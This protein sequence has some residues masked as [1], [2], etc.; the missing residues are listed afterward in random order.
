MAHSHIPYGQ[1][2]IDEADIEA[3]VDVLRSDWITQGELVGKFEEAL[4]EY[5][6]ANFAVAV[7]SATAALH[8][9]CM[10]AG[11]KT[12]QAV[13]TSPVIFDSP[14]PG[15]LHSLGV[16]AKTPGSGQRS[17]VGPVFHSL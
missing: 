17:G 14:V 12:G 3:V 13:L 8:L 9:A 11:V 15:G 5:C 6:Q 7:S 4:A 10:A 16:A 2:W 1:H